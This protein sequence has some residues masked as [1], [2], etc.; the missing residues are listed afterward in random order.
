MRAMILRRLGSVG[1]EAPPLELAEVPAPVAGDGEILI[2]V[3]VCGVCHTEL[4]EIEGRAPPSALPRI[5]GHQVVGTVEARGPGARAFELGARVGVAWIA[6]ACGRC[7]RC[8]RGDEN[9]CAD[10]RATGR[11]ID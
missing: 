11:D 3:A 9:L 1:A 10:F 6:G 5:L 8:R 4:D 7:D 2:R